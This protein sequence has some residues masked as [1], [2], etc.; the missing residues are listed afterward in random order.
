[1]YWWLGQGEG[2]PASAVVTGVTEAP[3]GSSVSVSR[4]GGASASQVLYS[5]GVGLQAG[6][7]GLSAAFS[8]PPPPSMWTPGTVAGLALGGLALGGL[9]AWAVS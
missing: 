3:V 7:A 2:E 8:P 4:K 9:V 5:L 6:G 1:M